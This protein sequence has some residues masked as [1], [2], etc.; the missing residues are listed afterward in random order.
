MNVYLL[1]KINILKYTGKNFNMFIMSSKKI[2]KKF[3]YKIE[4]F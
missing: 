2:T 3:N 1:N 4:L